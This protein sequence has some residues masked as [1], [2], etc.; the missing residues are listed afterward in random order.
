MEINYV[1]NRIVELQLFLR[2]GVQRKN[3]QFS[4]YVSVSL[5]CESF[6]FYE[7]LESDSINT[8]NASVVLEN[9]YYRPVNYEDLD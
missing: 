9:E 7:L 1:E 6:L 8:I 5:A 3:L 4:F 2:F